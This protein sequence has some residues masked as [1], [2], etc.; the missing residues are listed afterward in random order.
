MTLPITTRLGE[1]TVAALDD[2]VRAGPAATRAAV[3]AKVVEEWLACHSE[4]AIAAS[5]QHAYAERDEAHEDLI[6]RLGS[7]PRLSSRP[8]TISDHAGRRP[9]R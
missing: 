6:A 3:V 2:A 4:E 5:Y 7:S 1:E 8:S 9:H